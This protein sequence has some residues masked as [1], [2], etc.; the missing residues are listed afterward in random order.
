[1]K[2]NNYEQFTIKTLKYFYYTKN[3]TKNQIRNQLNKLVK[4]GIL[5]KTDKFRYAFNVNREITIFDFY[6]TNKKRNKRYT[7]VNPT[8]A[9]ISKFFNIPI[10]EL[11][12]TLTEEYKDILEGIKWEMA[13]E[14][15]EAREYFNQLL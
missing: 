1:M 3:L 8:I 13:R 4:K 7:K 9:K 10:N 2:Q 6:E 11:D 15:E 14:I 12:T 5:K